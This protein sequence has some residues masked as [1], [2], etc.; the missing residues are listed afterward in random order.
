[1]RK[2]DLSNFTFTAIIFFIGLLSCKDSSPDNT[3]NPISNHGE[4]II[5]ERDINQLDYKD[6]ALSNLSQKATKD[7]LKFQELQSEIAILKKGDTSFFKEDDQIITS[8]ISDLKNETPEA[9]KLPQIDSRIIVIETV[10]MQLKELS[11]YTQ[12]KKPQLL[13]S[14]KKVLVA[15]SNLVLQMNKKFEKD[16]QNIIKPN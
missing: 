6:F 12:T 15:N 11:T 13:E 16:S 7:W 3:N 14:I 8:F 9:L 10:I 5:T 4:I 2:S 1:M